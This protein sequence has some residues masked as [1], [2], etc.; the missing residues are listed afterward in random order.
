MSTRISIQGI[1]GTIT[2]CGPGR[3]LFSPADGSQ[4]FLVDEDV[5]VSAGVLTKA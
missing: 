4:A 3:W 2:D 5:L 1:C